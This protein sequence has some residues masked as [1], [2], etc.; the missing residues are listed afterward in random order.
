MG[1]TMR[2]PVTYGEAV[3]SE[4]DGTEVSPNNPF[5]LRLADLQ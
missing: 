3:E 1:Q 4:S 5:R 2:G